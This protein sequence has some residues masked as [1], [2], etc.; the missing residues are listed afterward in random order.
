MRDQRLQVA[1]EEL[2]GGALKTAQAGLRFDQ[3]GFDALGVIVDEPRHLDTD[4]QARRK[5]H[6]PQVTEQHGRILIRSCPG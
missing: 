4:Q 3:M 6:Q 2:L 5:Q 1:L